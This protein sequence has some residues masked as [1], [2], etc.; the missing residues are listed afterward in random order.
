MCAWLAGWNHRKKVTI[1]GQAGA[2]TDYQVDFSI[3]SAAGGDFN[4]ESHCTSF[5]NDIEVTDNDQTTPTD[6]WVEDLTVDPI[7][8]W[9]EVADDLGSNVDI[10]FYYGKSGATTQSDGDATFEFFDDFSGN[11][12]KW[13]TI[14]GSPTITSGVLQLES[15]GIGP[16]MIKADSLTLANFILEY[17]GRTTGVT[18]GCPH[19]MSFVRWQ[20]ESSGNRLECAIRDCATDDIYLHDGSNFYGKV[21]MWD[22]WP[23][24]GTTHWIGL[25]VVS[26]GS[27]FEIYADDLEGPS[28]ASTSATISSMP[29]NGTIAL[30]SWQGT[31]ID[32]YDNI[33]A[34][35]YNATEPAFSSAA[36]EESA[37]SAAIMNLF[38]GPNLGS[39]LYNGALIA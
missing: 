3:A 17:K 7:M 21:G 22:W 37:P 28:S 15:P 16:P 25:K 32:Q 23:G 13:T 35:K 38:Q 18:S 26:N 1:T 12:N 2:G 14:R 10:N 8:M 39:D 27:D 4:L 36:A 19:I 6:Y 5:P 34:R 30:G 31:V 20:S 9:V 33:R 11:L 29:A 24:S